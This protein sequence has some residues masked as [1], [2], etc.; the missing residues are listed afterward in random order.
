MDSDPEYNNICL[1][2]LQNTVRQS[3]LEDESSVVKP[4]NV[5]ISNMAIMLRTPG[6]NNQTFLTVLVKFLE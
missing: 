5:C 3:N 2:V 1:I 6:K 4:R